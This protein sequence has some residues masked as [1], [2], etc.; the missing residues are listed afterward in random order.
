MNTHRHLGFGAQ[1]AE[2]GAARCLREGTTSP[3]QSLLLRVLGEPVSR[4]EV[5]TSTPGASGCVTRT[6]AVLEAPSH[7]MCSTDTHFFLK[8]D[9]DFSD[10]SECQCPGL[11]EVGLWSGNWSTPMQ[12]NKIPPHGCSKSFLLFLKK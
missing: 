2:D 7:V 12:F 8:K 11:V 4:E 1:A 3:T 6:G 5:Q 10:S 9:K